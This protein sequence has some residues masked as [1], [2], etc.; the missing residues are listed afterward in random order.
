MMCTEKV[1]LSVTSNV[2]RAWK[3]SFS[4]ILHSSL[5]EKV[6]SER[7]SRRLPS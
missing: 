5:Y 1:V 3:I 4:E 6:I 2:D 7:S